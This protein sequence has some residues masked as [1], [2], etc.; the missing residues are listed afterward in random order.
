[1][2]FV[3]QR[4]RGGEVK[5]AAEGRVSAADAVERLAVTHQNA[6]RSFAGRRR[7]L[8]RNLAHDAL[9]AIRSEHSFDNNL[10]AGTS[11]GHISARAFETGRAAFADEIEIERDALH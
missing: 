9:T 1:M 10:I 2:L 5:L 8:Y 11:L 4:N 7:N 3:E 6:Q